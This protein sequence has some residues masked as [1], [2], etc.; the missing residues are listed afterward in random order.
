ME[1]ESYMRG[2]M[3]ALSDVLPYLARNGQV[4]FSTFKQCAYKAMA[5]SVSF[6]EHPTLRVIVG[7]G[8]RKTW[9]LEWRGPIDE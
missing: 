8:E 1:H 3:A 7:W 6:L 2:Y 5:T 9:S 4:S